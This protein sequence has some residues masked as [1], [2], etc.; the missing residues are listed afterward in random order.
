M[1]LSGTLRLPLAARRSAKADP[2]RPAALVLCRASGEALGGAVAGEL[3]AACRVPAAL[4]ACW[5][6]EEPSPQR[7]AAP[8]LRAARA[9]AERLS[10]RGVAAD[11]RGRLVWIDRTGEAAE[12]ADEAFRHA[13]SLDLPLVLALCGPRPEDFDERLGDFDLVVV[14]RVDGAASE[15]AVAEL[16]GHGVGAIA[17]AAPMDGGRLLALAGFGRSRGA[18]ADLA[19]ALA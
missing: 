14:E 10:R 6:A 8:S 13:D 1:S 4:L 16:D 5:H 7:R 9:A 19:A 2:I 17:C 3:R 12:F 15:V 11:A 18:F